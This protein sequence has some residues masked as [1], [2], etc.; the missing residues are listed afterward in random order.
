MFKYEKVTAQKNVTDSEQAAE[1][2]TDAAVAAFIRTSTCCTPANCTVN[3]GKLICQSSAP[4]LH[5]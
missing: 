5:I 4:P 1:V 3:I 2:Y